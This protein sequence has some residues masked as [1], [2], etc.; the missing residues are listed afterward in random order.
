MLKFVK[1]LSAAALL[2]VVTLSGASAAGGGVELKSASWNHTGMFG[3]YDRAAAQRGL[4]VYREVCAGCHG[5]GLVALRTLQDLG[6]T[7][8]EVKALSKEYPVMDGPDDEG[9]MFERP[10]K[11][12]DKFPS[13]F[14]NEKAARASNGGAYPLDL[15][16]VV[17][18]RPG[19][20]NYLYSLLTGYVDAPADFELNEGISDKEQESREPKRNQIR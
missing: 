12:S 16:L 6:F 18:A 9:E 2:S 14:A 3:T 15:S 11:P 20:E 4:Q 10:G 17:K 1:S 7:E 8:D 13:P 19:F 5:L